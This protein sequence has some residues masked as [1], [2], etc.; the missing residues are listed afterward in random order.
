MIPTSLR[1]LSWQFLKNSPMR[2]NIVWSKK[3]YILI[4]LSQKTITETP[5]FTKTNP[6]NNPLDNIPD[7]DLEVNPYLST[8]VLHKS[9]EYVTNDILE[10]EGYL[11]HFEKQENF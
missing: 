7:Y 6:L 9:Q 10:F 11:S 4:E 8:P 1:T 3:N 2:F 5:T